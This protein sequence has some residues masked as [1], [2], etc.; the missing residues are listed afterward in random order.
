MGLPIITTLRGGIPEEVSEENA[1]LLETDE[2]F[3]DNLASAIL[4]LYRHPEK[5]EMMAS[6]SLKRSSL[7]EKD[8]FAK[9]FIEAIEARE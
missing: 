3:V 5:R 7:F 2:H 9:R 8:S 4:E 1:I 6:S